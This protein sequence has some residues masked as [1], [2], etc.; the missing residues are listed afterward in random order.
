MKRRGEPRYGEVQCDDSTE[1][2]LRGPEPGLTSARK[3]GILSDSDSPGG[4]GSRKTY[5]SKIF[6]AAVIGVLSPMTWQ[7]DATAKLS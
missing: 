1:G 7:K 6:L 3:A 4:L 2:G 5:S